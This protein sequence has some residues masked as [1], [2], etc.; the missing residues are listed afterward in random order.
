MK[1]LLLVCFLSFYPLFIFSWEYMYTIQKEGDK[2]KENLV[3]VYKC[4]DKSTATCKD[5]SIQPPRISCIGQF[6]TLEGVDTGKLLQRVGC[7]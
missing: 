5:I 6:R 7:L 4:K 1:K 2:K 3:R